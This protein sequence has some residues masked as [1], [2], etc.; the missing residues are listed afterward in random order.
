M[1]RATVWICNGTSNAINNYIRSLQIWGRWYSAWHAQAKMW[2]AL[3]SKGSRPFCYGFGTVLY[4]HHKSPQTMC[5][6]DT[7]QQS[8][9]QR[10]VKCAKWKVY[11]PRFLHAVNEG[12]P[13][14]RGQFCEWF[15]HKVKKKKSFWAK[16]SGLMN[17]RLSL[18]VQGIAITCV[19]GSRKI[20]H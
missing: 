4:D 14:R 12:D 16:L 15:K 19:W 9:A 17:Q 7:D 6:W 11:I 1:K 13:D 5:T 20:T 8:S 3:H 2:K 18:M 10:I